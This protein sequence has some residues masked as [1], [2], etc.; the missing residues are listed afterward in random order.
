MDIT[1]IEVYGHHN[2]GKII[3]RYIKTH[4]GSEDVGM[5]IVYTT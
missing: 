2:N 3:K 4:L 1:L 5:Y